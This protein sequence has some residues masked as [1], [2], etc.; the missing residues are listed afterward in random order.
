MGATSWPG[1]LEDLEREKEGA[2][3]GLI[4]FPTLSPCPP[5]FQI[6]ETLEEWVGEGSAAS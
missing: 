6:A 4:L 1:C 3:Q 2:L 5:T